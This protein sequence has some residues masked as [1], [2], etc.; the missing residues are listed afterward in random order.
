M[1]FKTKPDNEEKTSELYEEETNN[2]IISDFKMDPEHRKYGFNDEHNENGKPIKCYQRLKEKTN[3][4]LNKTMKKS[5]QVL[6]NFGKDK[7]KE[8]LLHSVLFSYRSINW[9]NALNK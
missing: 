9:S 5:E 7:G 4:N 2:P 6:Q 1:A 8:R 3:S